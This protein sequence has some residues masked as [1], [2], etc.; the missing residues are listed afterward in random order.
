MPTYRCDRC[1][2]VDNTALTNFWPDQADHRRERLCS[3][4]DPRIGAWHG[5]F[6]RV[7]WTREHAKCSG[8]PEEIVRAWERD[9]SAA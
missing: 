5:K 8:M 7:I 9:K 6:E 4:C 1:G 2:C 3:E